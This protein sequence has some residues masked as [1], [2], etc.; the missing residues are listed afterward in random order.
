M[1]LPDDQA[2][3]G[4]V[5]WS[6]PMPVQVAFIRNTHAEMGKGTVEQVASRFVKVA[7]KLVE[8]ILQSLAALGQAR[9]ES[10]KRFA[11]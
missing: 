11:A 10:S 9:T 3:E 4:N 6:A 2:E 5:H 1:E 8:V 7:R